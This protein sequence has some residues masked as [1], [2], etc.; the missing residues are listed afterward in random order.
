MKL[1]IVSPVAKREYLEVK[2]VKMM[3]KE[4]GEMEIW[5]GHTP[6]LAALAAGELIIKKANGE[7]ERVLI[8]EGVVKQEGEEVRILTNDL[9]LAQDLVNED[10]EEAIKRAEEKKAGATL[11]TDLIQ[12]EKE[13]RYQKLKRQVRDSLGNG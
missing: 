1:T 6:M 12:I 5:A 10:I 4:G 8:N 11:P 7:T 9:V 13:I 3:G 2:L